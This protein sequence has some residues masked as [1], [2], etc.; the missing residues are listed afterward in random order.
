[1][2]VLDQPPPSD[3][4]AEMALLGELLRD[5]SALTEIGRLTSE[6]AELADWHAGKA[7]EERQEGYFFYEL[8]LMR[9][10]QLRALLGEAPA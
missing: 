10:E 5:S 8:R 6:I 3:D 9:A 7:E 4:R 1:M 2:T